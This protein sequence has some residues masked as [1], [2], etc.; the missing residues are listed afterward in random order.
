MTWFK[1][2]P[3]EVKARLEAL[4]VAPI[5]DLI[6]HDESVVYIQYSSENVCYG[7]LEFLKDNNGFRMRL[8]QPTAMGWRAE[9]SPH[10]RYQ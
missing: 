7:V 2:N 1:V 3:M 9:E 4:G 10:Y 5:G 6:G 8:Y